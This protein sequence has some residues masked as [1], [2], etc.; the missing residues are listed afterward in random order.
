MCVWIMSEEAAYIMQMQMCMYTIAK[1]ILWAELEVAST[2]INW[3]HY[4]T[5]WG[6]FWQ[7]GRVSIEECTECTNLPHQTE[8]GT[9]RYAVGKQDWWQE[10]PRT[11]ANYSWCYEIGIITFMSTSNNNNNHH[12]HNHE[13]NHNMHTHTQ[14][15]WYHH[16][17][18]SLSFEYMCSTSG[19]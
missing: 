5:C 17:L 7:R 19:V 8:K 3:Y 14:D 2:P 18:T 11:T 1:P 12:Y 6:H 9:K 4:V 15:S 10:P 16:C 13:H